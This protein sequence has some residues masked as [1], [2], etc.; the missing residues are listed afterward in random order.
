MFRVLLFALLWTA[1]T[2][3]RAQLTN[4]PRTFNAISARV[5]AIDHD[6]ANEPLDDPDVTFGLEL[7]LRRQFGKYFGVMVPLKLGVIDVGEVDNIT[8]VGLEALAQLY[9]LG[10]DGKVVPYLHAGYGSVSERFEDANHQIPLGVGLN[11]RLDDNSWFSLQ[12]EYR[13]SDQRVRD[14]V[15]IGAGYIY[16]LS[17]LDSDQDGIVNRNDRCPNAPGPLNTNGCPDA[18]RDGIVDEEDACPQQAGLAQF[19]GCPDTDR[20]GLTDAKDDCPE[21]AGPAALMGCPDTDGDGISDKMDDCPEAAGSSA[22][23]GCPDTD[24]DG[25]SDANDRC[26]EVAGTDRLFGCPDTDND[27]VG[28]DKDECPDAPG[29]LAT[30]GCPDDDNDGTPNK[31]DRCPGQVGPLNGCPDTDGDGVS[32]DRDRCP[33]QP[34]TEANEGCP[35]VEA[36]VQERLAYAARAVQF[37]TG[38]AQLKESSYVVL[39]EVAGIMRQYPDYQL[40]IGGH[41]DNVGSDANN[42]QLSERRAAACRKFIVATGI[43]AGRI[44][45]A[46]FGETQP[47]A[48]NDTAEGRRQNRRVV[49][50]LIPQ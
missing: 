32:D 42:L 44:R 12:G 27:G 17:S 28:D 13:L 11:F 48:G 2:G 3:L 50:E 5:L 35:E 45:S 38:S 20:D 9:P 31:D 37:E 25:I 1:A 18:D 8:I 19:Q 34:G 30:K 26:P 29:P 16:R 4:S 15:M 47:V 21:L 41:T 43:D 39:S 24:G 36:A 6:W 22:T 33:T 14:N 40:V 46:G 23:M 10:N 49:F 7:G